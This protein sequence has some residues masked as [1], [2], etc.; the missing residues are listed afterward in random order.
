MR[1]H[2]YRLEYKTPRASRSNAGAH[3]FSP[4]ETVK[5]TIFLEYQDEIY[6]AGKGVELVFMLEAK[7]PMEVQ[8]KLP[9]H[10]DEEYP[11]IDLSSPELETL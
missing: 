6:V 11:I 9:N 1:N 3:H 4:H 2:N 5:D 7:I 10:I 8:M